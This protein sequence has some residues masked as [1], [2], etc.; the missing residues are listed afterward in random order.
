M[1]EALWLTLNTLKSCHQASRY[2]T[3]LL[4]NIVWLCPPLLSTGIPINVSGTLMPRRWFLST[5]MWREATF[6]C[7]LVT[8]SSCLLPC[9]FDYFVL[10]LFRFSM[11]RW[12][13]VGMFCTS[14]VLCVLLAR[15]VGIINSCYVRFSIVGMRCKWL[16][17]FCLL[18]VSLPLI[19]NCLTC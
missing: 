13:L 11:S 6:W 9:H 3:S 18:A 15:W 19:F 16:L 7:V 10:T 17:C 8:A 1:L 2:H 14:S 12:F 4:A 5:V